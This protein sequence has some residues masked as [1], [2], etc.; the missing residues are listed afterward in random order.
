MTMH[1][2]YIYIL[3]FYYN[4]MLQLINVQSLKC[5]ATWMTRIW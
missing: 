3:H 5:I 4:F 2:N 1:K